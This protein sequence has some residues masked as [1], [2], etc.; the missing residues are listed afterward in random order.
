MIG[1]YKLEHILGRG[2]TSVVWRATHTLSG[3]DVAIKILTSERAK[4]ARYRE[5]FANEVRAVARLN[6]VHIAQVVDAG[7]LT[8]SDP[9]RDLFGGNP[10]VVTEFLAGG[11]LEDYRRRLQWKAVRDLLRAVLDALAHAHAHGVLHLDIKPGNLLLAGL[12]QPLVPVLT[13][14]GIARVSESE[15]FRDEQRVTGT[16]R[17]M[18]PEQITG[19]WADQGPWTDLYGLG[20]LAYRLICGRV[21]FD[22]E[23]STEILRAHV[24]EPLPEFEPMI[25]VP[26]GIKSWL[27]ML[28]SKD[29]AH[30]PR[31]A[32][33][34]AWSLL[35]SEIRSGDEW[36]EPVNEDWQEDAEET[37]IEATVITPALGPNDTSPHSHLLPGSRP[38]IPQN[39]RIHERRF[40]RP[41][42]GYVGLGMARHRIP[43]F[44][45][46]EHERD[47][48][49]AALWK[50]NEAT[51]H[52]VLI[53]GKTGIGKSRLVDWCARLVDELGIG[54]PLVARFRHPHA[55]LGPVEEAL[56]RYARVLHLKPEK[57]LSRLRNFMAQ[58]RS[59]DEGDLLDA[60]AFCDALRNGPTGPIRNER[61]E[62]ASRLIVRIAEHMPV[63]LVLDDADQE[64]DALRLVDRLLAGHGRILCLIT[65]RGTSNSDVLNETITRWQ[66]GGR[67]E[68]LKLR[69]LPNPELAQMI[70]HVARI[71]PHL[72]KM[73]LDRSHGSPAEGIQ[74]L[75]SWLD[76]EMLIPG[77]DGYELA[78]SRDSV[79]SE[80][81]H[82][83]AQAAALALLSRL[84]AT[85]RQAA[86]FAAVLGREIKRREWESVLREAIL[87]G[88]DRLIEDI[89]QSGLIFRDPNGA[90]LFVDENV[91]LAVL[92]TLSEDVRKNAEA[93][94]ADTLESLYAL[95]DALFM[96]RLAEHRKD[97][98]DLLAAAELFTLAA[99]RFLLTE[100]V[101]EAERALGF[102]EDLRQSHPTIPF[103]LAAHNADVARLW[104]RNET[105]EL[106]LNILT[107]TQDACEKDGA[108]RA[109]G[110]VARLR[111]K[112]LR[113][114]S[115]EAANEA[116]EEAIGMLE[117]AGEF[118]EAGSLML[119]Q[120]WNFGLQGEYDRAFQT[121]NKAQAI[122]RHEGD[123]HWVG[124][125]DQA[126]AFLYLQCGD[127]VT[128]RQ[129]ID[130]LFHIARTLGVR[131]LLSSG[132]AYL[133]E[134]ERTRGNAEE[135]LAHY[136]DVV[137]LLGPDS[138]NGKIAMLNQSLCRLALG[139]DR[140]ALLVMESVTNDPQ[141]RAAGLHNHVDLARLSAEFALGEVK[142]DWQQRWDST[143]RELKHYKRHEYD[144]AWLLE[145]VGKAFDTQHHTRQRDEAFSMSEHI[146][147]GLG[148]ESDAERVRQ[149]QSR[150]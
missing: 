75:M 78:T 98:G 38:P 80:S 144:L 89:V 63:I 142:E 93:V 114:K 119:S 135:A 124:K 95:T 111:A 109:A 47:A 118:L 3:E 104:L 105:Q 121:L 69:E 133:G 46:R 106:D 37:I 108:F 61:L 74:H 146:W 103:T 33:E 56:A 4:S 8:E 100:Q 107:A 128:A 97:A 148:R 34:A 59:V 26:K 20:C 44:V 127:E 53:E 139:R 70:T 79:E 91:R 125:V 10:Y 12:K 101:E 54:V 28:L 25:A 147:R 102:F 68:V 77:I 5:Y 49:W 72:M 27:H 82:E 43:P 130:A 50:A 19:D 99:M 23:R 65:S 30:R 40:G 110:S 17:Y 81:K 22:Y 116:I 14:F 150:G 88:P 64:S 140:E 35:E 136:S 39:W 122:F 76:R 129:R 112:A 15:Q 2:G 32:A 96:E 60:V 90:Y 87:P 83:I 36:W 24:R 31:S 123:L 42:P 73:L 55:G 117:R 66:L 57:A 71:E 52:A 18:A 1:P 58:L 11:T 41:R 13:D 149:L 67:A 85:A 143:L 134:F 94:V 51:P 145:H 131:S 21:P 141:I 86:V 132:H 6:H 45:G 113:K 138:L 115:F 29:P 84:D 137:T 16:P 9:T 48:L 62:I 92:E 126:A 7:V 120:G